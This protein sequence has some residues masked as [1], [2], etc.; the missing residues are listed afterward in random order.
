MGAHR[1]AITD[2]RQDMAHGGQ[3]SAGRGCCVGSSG[4]APTVA[5]APTLELSDA[6]TPKSVRYWR[7]SSHDLATGLDVK[8]FSDTVSQPM[9]D[10]CTH[11]SLA[12][13]HEHRRAR[14]LLW[15]HKSL[16]WA[17]PAVLRQLGGSRPRG[18]RPV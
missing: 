3:R 5:D 11:L 12:I 7:T 9:F 16:L 17:A 14:F 13:G 2:L 18:R 4:A 1:K 10:K 6:L 15:H 8:D